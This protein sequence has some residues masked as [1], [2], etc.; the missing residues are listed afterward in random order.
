MLPCRMQ[1]AARQRAAAAVQEQNRYTS[2][3][4]A[5]AEQQRR[6]EERASAARD[7][8]SEV[9]LPAPAA[10][11]VASVMPVFLNSE[12]DIPLVLTPGWTCAIYAGT[13]PTV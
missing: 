13:C 1:A 3:S 4:R 7:L 2:A 10:V 12:T 5:A 11:C 9:P 6:L 8:Q